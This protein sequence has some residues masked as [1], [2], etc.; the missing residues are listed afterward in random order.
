MYENN[1]ENWS[2]SSNITLEFK[3]L[4]PSSQLSMNTHTDTSTAVEVKK[5]LLLILIICFFTRWL[6][7]TPLNNTVHLVWATDCQRLTLIAEDTG[8]LL[9]AEALE[10]LSWQPGHS[11]QCA[12]P[13]GRPQARTRGSR[14]R[15]M[16]KMAATHWL[17]LCC[18]NKERTGKLLLNQCCANGTDANFFSIPINF[19]RTIEV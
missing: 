9:W 16:T 8:R 18:N 11:G 3:I 6:M 1:S 15:H 14:Q 13:A 19:L 7:G 5:H 17:L 4:L 10:Q 2:I 12:R